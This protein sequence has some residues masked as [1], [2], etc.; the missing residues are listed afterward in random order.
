MQND[1][2][3]SSD[4]N[5]SFAEPASLRKPDAPGF[6]RRPFCYA[7][8]QDIG[9]LVEITSQH[10]IAAFRDSTRPVD[11]AGC[12]SSGRQ[13]D[14]GSDASRSLESTGV[15]DRRKKAKSGDWTDARRCHEP[16]NMSIIAGQ[17]HHLAV[18][19]RNLPPDSLACLEKRL[20][21]GS[22]F[23][24]SLGQLRGA[25]SKHV[26]LCPADDEPK[27]LEE[28]ADLVLN[29][30]LDLDEQSSADKNGLNRVTVEIF[31]ADLLV[32]STL[33]DACNAHGVVTVALVDLHLQNRLRMPGIDADDGQPHLIQLG[34]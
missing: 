23:W 31:D 19:V 32:P 18:E 26:H 2:K 1:S 8:E 28:P 30:P 24:P 17:P 12:I 4:G 6:K 9:C 29:V 3:L 13:S 14:I 22:K 7:G 5:L 10:L 16:S 15:I 33:H 27:I 25:R 20:Y 34:P 21:R 11:L